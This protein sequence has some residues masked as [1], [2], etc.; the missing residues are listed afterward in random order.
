MFDDD[1]V[2]T[3]H[4]V[5]SALADIE[6]TL[7][8]CIE[9]PLY[10]L[11]DG[12]VED[13]L[14][15]A[16]ALVA[17][18]QGGLMLPLVRQAET[19]GLPATFEA[20]N[21][22]T[23]L[24]HLLRLHPGQARQMVT[25]AAAVESDFGATGRAVAAGQV[26]LAHAAAVHRAV[27][28]IP[29][30]A[31]AWVRPD[32]E[33]R[34]VEWSAEH[35]PKVVARLGRRILEIVDPEGADEILRRQLERQERAAAEAVELRLFPEAEG[36]VRLA[37]WLGTEGAETLRAALDPLAAPQPAGPEGPDPRSYPQRMADALV[38][39]ARRSLRH[40]DLPEHGGQPPTVVLTM[41]YHRLAEKV[42]T[43][44]LDTGEHLSA[45]AARRLACDA[46]ILPAVLGGASQP[47]DLGRAARTITG[48]LRRALV[49][50]DKG[51]AFPYC[52]LPPSWCQGH[53][54]AHWADGGPTS[55]GNAVLL[56]GFHHTTIHHG[57]W[58]VRIAPDG[59]PEF[60]PP[61]W[62]DPQQRPRRNYQH[63]PRPG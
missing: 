51:C 45:A 59:I 55:L 24:R 57:E 26:S 32:A 18:I 38:E 14:V 23:W 22:T 16:Q 8:S 49:L 27:T 46:L 10:G 54:V 3:G 19:R 52:D 35:D 25:L 1:G 34:L 9:V 5:L 11:R 6:Q 30:E 2:Q 61:P 40:G 20:P 41:D 36:R 42:G 31:A 48:P 47:L 21:T 43:A 53:H 13:A 7:A 60:T 50:R 44:G 17:R 58:Q 15:Q 28:A 63:Q 4:P 39:L 12:E 62:V 37:G 56:C 33:A 29:A